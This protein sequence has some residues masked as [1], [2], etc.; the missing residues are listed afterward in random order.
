L[1][2][3]DARSG[4][5]VDW[6]GSTSGG[7]VLALCAT[8][9]GLAAGGTFASAGGQPRSNLALLDRASGLATDWDPGADGAV[10]AFALAGTTLYCGGDFN[11]IG[12]EPR[13]RLAALS[14]ATGGPEPWDPGANAGVRALAFQ[15][16]IVYAGGGFTTAGG[17]PRVCL[18]ALHP[19][20]GAALP[21]DVA[22]ELG[23]SVLAVS[24]AGGHVFA[25]GTQVS[26]GAEPTRGFGAF[27]APEPLLD[28]RGSGPRRARGEI[29]VEPQ[30][31]RTVA[32]VKL[33]LP[34]E[35]EAEIGLY[36]LTGR[37]LAILE[38]WGHR[39]AGEV[40]IA[41]EAR[42]LQPG[43]YLVRAV[44]PEG[45]LAGKLVVVP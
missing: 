17:Q 18:A 39:P 33:T 38:P 25:G 29:R 1:L 34:R 45:D 44:T 4:A 10:S 13:A 32:Q 35:T 26:A 24:V 28:V 19:A 3:L 14:L 43:I 22:I 16:G 9:A 20:T 7:A 6:A 41:L 5:S 23:H 31:A 21:W 37:R 42:K 27:L 11:T 36:D 8:P 15:Q 30:P 12:G 2:A 40:T